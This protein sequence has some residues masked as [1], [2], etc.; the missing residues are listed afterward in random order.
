MVFFYTYD[1]AANP[2]WFL[3]LGD[4]VNGVLQG[5]ALYLSKLDQAFWF[6]ISDIAAE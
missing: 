5:N 1:E 6:T 4:M 3:C 2:D